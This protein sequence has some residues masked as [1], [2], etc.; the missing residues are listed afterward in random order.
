MKY[1]RHDKSKSVK[2]IFPDKYSFFLILFAAAFLIINTSVVNAFGQQTLTLDEIVVS[3]DIITDAAR[4][5]N[6][7]KKTIEQG[8]NI[9]VADI[10]KLGAEVDI[11]RNAA[12]G[13]TGDIIS[14]RGLS[15]NRILLTVNGRPMTASGIVGGYYIDWSGIPLDNIEKI[16]VIKG[17]SSALYGNNAIGGVINIITKKPEAGRPKTTLYAMGAK[18]DADGINDNF[19]I[20]HAAKKDKFG[21]L[22]SFGRQKAPEFLWNNDFTGK[23]GA[24]FLYYDMPRGAKLSFSGQYSNTRRGFIRNNRQSLDSDSPLFGLKINDAYPLSLGEALTGSGVNNL[25]NIGPGAYWDKDKYLYDMNYRQPFNDGYFEVK[26]YKNKEDR[27]EKNY[28]TADGRLVLDRVVESDRSC[29]GSIQAVKID[30]NNETTFGVERKIIAN[31][32]IAVNFV[33]NAYNG[34]VYTGTTP[35]NEGLNLNYYVQNISRITDR[36]TVTA[37]LRRYDYMIHSL[38]PSTKELSGSGLSPKFSANYD[39]MNGQSLSFSAYHAERT[40]GLPEIYWAQNAV[41]TIGAARLPVALPELKTERN[42]AAEIS[43]E[44]KFGRTA[45]IRATAYTY[46]ISDYIMSRFETNWTGI[47]NID[48]VAVRGFSLEA[49]RKLGKLSAVS[50]NATWQAS[51][52]EGDLFDAD[53]LLNGLDSMPKFKFNLNFER[54]LPGFRGS[55]AAFGA[56]YVGPQDQIYTFGKNVNRLVRVNAFT[57]FDAGIKIPVSRGHQAEIFIDNIFDK[58]YEE[59]FGY[60]L[61]GRTVGASMKLNF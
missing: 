2:F 50:A 32:D 55:T 17:G 23:N 14:I 48:A 56:R 26:Y 11:K 61:M 45:S 5:N 33:D 19:K 16:E 60:P 57:L 4:K 38:T 35:N 42:R 22:V 43:Y 40:P 49:E 46:R 41:R 27:K 20:S 37:G 1:N 54:T 18:N 10:L 25:A 29:G 30:G 59:K 7:G 15:K 53:K 44:K 36:L 6:I 8:K 13:D 34:R 51:S 3:G 9:N 21:Y 39:L 28:S 52:K 47:Y 58:K 12:A 24:L 31:G